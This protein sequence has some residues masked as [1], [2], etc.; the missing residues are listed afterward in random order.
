MVAV[1]SL[2][3]GVDVTYSNKP[4]FCCKPVQR[5]VHLESFEQRLFRSGAPSNFASLRIDADGFTFFD[6]ERNAD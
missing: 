6:K 4:Q 5:F 2:L 3:E 1:F